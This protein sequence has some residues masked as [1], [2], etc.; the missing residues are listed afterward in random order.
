MLVILKQKIKKQKI[1]TKLD[2]ETESGWGTTNGENHTGGFRA[3]SD[4]KHHINYLVVLAVK[5]AITDY[6]K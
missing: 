6:R 1:K 4:R 2:A 3:A 5:H